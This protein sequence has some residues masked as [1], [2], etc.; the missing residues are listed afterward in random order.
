M[1]ATEAVEVNTLDERGAYELAF[2]VLPTVAEGE[3]ARVYEEIKTLITQI[4]GEVITGEAPEHIELA[5]EI[6][7]HLESKNRTFKTAYF[8]WVRFK[9]S[10]ERIAAL[11]EELELRTDIL[12]HMLLR[13]TKIEEATPFY[14]HQ[15]RENEKVVVVDVGE[16]LANDGLASDTPETAADAAPAEVAKPEVADAPAEAKEVEEKEEK[17][18]DEEVKA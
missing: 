5:Y 12:R 11:T 16:A 4:D 6:V 17:Q 9:T 10:P 3:V 1:P 7:K 15:T 18:D 8:G 2:H 13:L 14:F